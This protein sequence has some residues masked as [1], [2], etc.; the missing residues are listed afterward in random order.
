MGTFL[1][2]S[3]TLEQRARIWVIPVAK[4]MCQ[5]VKNRAGIHHVRITRFGGAGR[6]L[7]LELLTEIWLALLVPFS[8]VGERL[9][10]GK[11]KDIP[12]C[13]AARTHLLNRMT[14]ELMA[15]HRLGEVWSA[16]AIVSTLTAVSSYAMKSAGCTP[17]LAGAGAATPPCSSFRSS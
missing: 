7:G 14:E 5:V 9:I 4:A 1:R 12:K 17:L 6:P 15:I 10:R 11:N 13:A 2:E 16:I 3:S 8:G